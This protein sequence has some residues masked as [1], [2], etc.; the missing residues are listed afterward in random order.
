MPASSPTLLGQDMTVGNLQEGDKAVFRHPALGGGIAREPQAQLTDHWCTS[1]KDRTIQ[2][3][4]VTV[5]P[6]PGRP[7]QWAGEH[8]A[9]AQNEDAELLG[10]ETLIVEHR[11]R[12]EHH[13]EDN[14]APVGAC[15]AHV[16]ELLR[17]R[18]HQEST[19]DAIR[20]SEDV[21]NSH[22]WRLPRR[23]SPHGAH[24]LVV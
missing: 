11:P 22:A 23:S 10:W 5:L 19:G 24:D 4:R 17:G 2:H 8:L 15:H 13:M 16:G 12:F 21:G 18:V 6:N 7:V 3:I 14:G 9:P 20:V 1:G